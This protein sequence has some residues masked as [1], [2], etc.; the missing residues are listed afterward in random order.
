MLYCITVS[1]AEIIC[2]AW[3]LRAASGL[4]A[5]RLLRSAPDEGVAAHLE[6]LPAA[7]AKNSHGLVRLV[8]RFQVRSSMQ[9]CHKNKAKCLK[10]L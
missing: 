3:L 1:I 2:C 8:G 6:Q 9:V 5:S 7:H 10:Q 4:L